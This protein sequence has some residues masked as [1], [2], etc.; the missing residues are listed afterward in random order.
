MGKEKHNRP[1]S[2]FKID[3]NTWQLLRDKPEIC[4]RNAVT[5]AQWII[6]HLNTMRTQARPQ[7]QDLSCLTC[8]TSRTTLLSP[9]STIFNKQNTKYYENKFLC[10]NAVY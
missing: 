8:G 5:D 7:S 6:T 9:C 3:Y 4:F 1:D 10:T 2:V